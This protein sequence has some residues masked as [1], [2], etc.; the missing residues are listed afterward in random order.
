[1][2]NISA[3]GHFDQFNH[4]LDGRWVELRSSKDDWMPLSPHFDQIFDRYLRY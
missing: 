2:G 1:M 3:P 4:R